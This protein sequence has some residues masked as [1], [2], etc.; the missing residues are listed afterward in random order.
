MQH[1]R[2]GAPRPVAA[3]WKGAIVGAENRPASAAGEWRPTE[4]ACRPRVS[5]V[6]PCYNGRSYL[7]DCLRSIAGLAGTDWEVL[8]I[9]DGSTEEI[10]GTVEAFAPLAR[11]LW[12]PNQGPSAARNTGL[13]YARGEYVRFLD[14][15]DYLISAESMHRQVAV[16]D[17]HPE[18]G[19]VYGQALKVDPAGRPFGVRKPGFAQSSYVRSGRREIEDLLFGNYMTTSSVIARKDVLDRA[20]G[21]RPELFSGE[22]W[23]CWLRIAWVS[24]V[25]YIAEP[26][27]AYR[28]HDKSITANYS[29]GPWLQTH[30]D[31]LDALFSDPEF[32]ARYGPL[33][34]SIDARLY[35]HAAHVAYSAGQMDVARQ[36]AARAGHSFRR[37]RRWTHLAQCSW[38]VARSRVPASM[39]PVLRG[40][41]RAARR[42]GHR[43][44][45]AREHN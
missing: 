38:L 39:R 40:A 27:A 26:I 10:R 24:A 15:D 8:V 1:L 18:V 44:H 22:D 9:D 31:I 36:Y 33:R 34:E 23:E 29:L 25:A 16:L 42:V 7:E 30:F 28:V 2:A 13:E 11:Y 5:F 3:S 14:S 35:A 6:I 4:P 32:A 21:F 19:L 45:P 17:S 12:Q 41:S 20:G 43:R 37:E